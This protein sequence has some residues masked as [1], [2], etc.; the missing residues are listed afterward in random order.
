M[1]QYGLDAKPPRHL[2]HKYSAM[3]DH[4][5]F[6]AFTKL[7]ITYRDSPGEFGGADNAGG[8][9]PGHTDAGRGK[10]ARNR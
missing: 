4:S 3:T 10:G 6:G 1:A 7:K 5:G 9:G 8:D 2:F